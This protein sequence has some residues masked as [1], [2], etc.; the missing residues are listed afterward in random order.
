MNAASIALVA[1]LSMC[2]FSAPV[3]RP[4]APQNPDVINPGHLLYDEAGRRLLMV[5]AHRLSN[6]PEH[7]QLW[8]WKDR[9]WRLLDTVLSP[10]M[11]TLTGTAYD[12]RRKRIVLFG[13][14]GNKGL[15][16][17]RSDTWEWDGKRWIDVSDTAIGSRDHHSMVFDEER[18]R[19]VMFGGVASRVTPEGTVR[20]HP[21]ETWEWDGRRW[22]RVST[23]GPAARGGAAMIYDRARKIVVMFGGISLVPGVT[24]R[25][26]DTWTWDGHTWRKVSESGPS[27][28][29][30]AAIAFDRRTNSVVM[31]GGTTG[32]THLDDMWRW[33]G[34]EWTQIPAQGPAPTRRTGAAMVYDKARHLIVFFGGQIRAGGQVITSNEMWEL[35]GG[36]WSQVKSGW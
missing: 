25:F 5:G 19:T 16:D 17:P 29:N 28:R 31:W 30:G 14:L 20:E 33:D 11:R 34:K 23:T 22:A 21:A 12:S 6:Q 24:G 8:E 32:P 35:E 13:G 9:E 1:A 36:R 15:A 2:L 3:L 7:V 26:S 27:G 10:T 4:A 18:R